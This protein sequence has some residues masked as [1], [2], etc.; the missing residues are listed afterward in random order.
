MQI[1]LQKLIQWVGLPLLKDLISS[2][3]SFVKREVEIQKAKRE[4]SKKK[5]DSNP[6]PDDFS[7]L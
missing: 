5:T 4:I 7:K 6:T 1:I 3:Y 2:L